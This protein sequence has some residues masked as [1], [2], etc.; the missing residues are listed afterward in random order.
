MYI[1][2]HE[3]HPF[4]MKITRYSWKSPV[5]HENHPFFMKIT[6]YSW[7]SPVL[8]ENHPI[9]V[10]I[11]RSSWKSPV[12]YENRQFFV[13]ITRSSRKSPVLHESHLLITSDFIET[14]VFSTEIRKKREKYSISGKCAKWESSYSWQINMTKLLR[15]FRNFQKNA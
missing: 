9:F 11:T 1:V 4:F 6:R 8:H 2:L 13:K 3:N 7:K 10:K 5:L 14:W 15:A 12:F